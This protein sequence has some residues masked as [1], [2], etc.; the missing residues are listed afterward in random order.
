M[1]VLQISHVRC[2]LFKGASRTTK[3]II[4][5]N[6]IFGDLGAGRL[7]K[8]N[9]RHRISHLFALWSILLPGRSFHIRCFSQRY[10]CSLCV[11]LSQISRRSVDQFLHLFWSTLR[12]RWSMTGANN[13][14]QLVGY[15]GS[16]VVQSADSLIF[17]VS[18][19]QA[20]IHY[21][22]VTYA[23]CSWP[24]I[25]WAWA[26]FV[27]GFIIHAGYC[28]LCSPEACRLACRFAMSSCWNSHLVYYTLDLSSPAVACCSRVSLLFNC[29]RPVIAPNCCQRK[30]CICWLITLSK[31]TFVL[32]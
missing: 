3:S 9:Q 21:A 27:D 18:A 12:N 15:T 17:M 14:T 10:P 32:L 11:D 16:V 29:E 6:R 25:Q 7:W 31:W 22:F 26:H 5:R 13:L 30:C 28:Y 23:T 4:Q 8:G 24:F 20:K 2:Y 1:Y 19:F